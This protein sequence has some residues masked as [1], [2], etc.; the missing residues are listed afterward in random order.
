MAHLS[1]SPA[2]ASHAALDTRMTNGSRG[3]LVLGAIVTIWLIAVVG[4][5]GALLSY[6]STPGTA[7]EPPARWPIQSSIDPKPGRATLVMLAH[8]H[9]PCTR[10]SIHELALLMT[11]LSGELSATVLF[12]RPPGADAD[13]EA[14]D[15][16]RSATAIPGVTVQVD[17]DGHEARIFRAQTSG[18]TVVYDATGRLVFSGGITP[19]RGHEGDNVGRSAIVTAVTTSASSGVTNAVFGCSLFGRSGE[20]ERGL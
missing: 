9:C 2:I 7:A 6:K 8:P 16:L 10:A 20:R 19:S 11:R 3:R 15:L 4:G 13:W 12:V 17:D 5:M 14:T 1:G 18:Q